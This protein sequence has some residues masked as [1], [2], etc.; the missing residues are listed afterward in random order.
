MAENVVHEPGAQWS[1][2]SPA[3]ES[4]IID[5]ATAPGQ[6]SAKGTGDLREQPRQPIAM[7]AIL[8]LAQRIAERFQPERI[9]FFGSYAYGSPTP[10][11]DVDLLVVMETRLRSREQCLEISRA[12]SPRPFPLDIVVCTPQE[13]ARRIARGDMFLHEIVTRDKVI[14]ERRRG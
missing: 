8:A 12:I 10:D 14:Y 6:Q 5:S 7:R 11:S 1:V 13:M 4:S 3:L 9:I 2:T